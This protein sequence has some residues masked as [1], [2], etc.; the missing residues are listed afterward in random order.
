MHDWSKVKKFIILIPVYNDWKSLRKLLENINDNIKNISNTE[1][2]CVIINDSSPVNNSEIRVP[3]NINSIK[4]IH[5]YKNRGH[6]RCNAFGIKY[7][8][9]KLDLDYVILMDS[10]GEDR[11]EELKLLINKILSEPEMSVVAKRVKRSEGFLF[12]LLYQ[13]HK[14]LTLSMTGKLINFGNYSCLTKN[15]LDILSTKAS[16]WSS[17]SGSFKKYIKRYNEINSFRGMR[18]FG[19]S[20]MSLF[21]LIIHSLS[22]MA[23]FKYHV[24]VI[25]IILILSLQYIAIIISFNFLFFQIMIILFN[26]F[27]FIVSFRESE[28]ELK[29]SDSNIK[30][31]EEFTHHKV[32]K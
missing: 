25:S 12:K 5:M 7:L 19:P 18:Y 27:V 4:I 23:V 29:S 24:F 17:F 3:S 15:D 14:Y 30:K 16:L 8:S 11:P 6:A 22:I 2:S 32:V 21:K 13:I 26:I 28:I 9:K 20:Q 10:D 1:F 31:I